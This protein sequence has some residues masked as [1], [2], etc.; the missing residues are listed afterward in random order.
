M[1]HHP[2]PTYIGDP[3]LIPVAVEEMLARYPDYDVDQTGIV[4]MRSSN[5]GGLAHLPVVVSPAA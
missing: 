2:S 5:V 1:Q 3:S 4:R